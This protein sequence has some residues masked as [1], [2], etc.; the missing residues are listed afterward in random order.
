MNKSCNGSSL[1]AKS[2]P[3]GWVVSKHLRE[4]STNADFSETH[5][6]LHTLSDKFNM[7]SSK[8]EL[9]FEMKQIVIIL[10]QSSCRKKFG[11]RNDAFSQPI[12]VN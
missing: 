10:I 12:N 8:C 6:I 3:P 7:S 11:S 1:I 4:G 9:N 2:L 5:C